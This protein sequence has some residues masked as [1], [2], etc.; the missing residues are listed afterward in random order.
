MFH[1]DFEALNIPYNIEGNVEKI[2]LNKS[3][4]IFF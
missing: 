4:Q 2:N 3:L 1:L